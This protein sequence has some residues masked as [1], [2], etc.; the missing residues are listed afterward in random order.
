MKSENILK[1]IINN[2]KKNNNE[3]IKLLYDLKNSMEKEHVKNNEEIIKKISTLYNLDE[4]QLSKR[5]LKKNKKKNLIQSE[6]SD[7]FLNTD[8]KIKFWELSKSKKLL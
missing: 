3:M 6:E 7:I 1:K 5:F 2:V 4:E 8:I